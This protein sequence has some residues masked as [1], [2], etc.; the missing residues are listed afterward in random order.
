MNGGR[1][2]IRTDERRSGRIYSPHPLATWIPYLGS[3]CEWSHLVDK[4][5]VGKWFFSIFEFD[6]TFQSFPFQLFILLSMKFS[7][8]HERIVVGL[9]GSIACGKSAVLL[10]LGE[11]GW[12]CFSTDKIAHR[13]LLE[14]DEV[15]Q[16]IRDEFGDAVFSSEGTV[17]KARLG[18]V[19]F[20]QSSKR[21][22]LEELLHPLIRKEWLHAVE[23]S[24]AKRIAVE[25]PLLF[26]NALE[27]EF[28]QVVTVFTNETTQMKRLLQRGLSSTEAEQRIS[29]QLPSSE[30]ARMADFVLF[31]D[32]SL[33]YLRR[34]VKRL[35]LNLA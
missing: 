3:F 24:E 28:D 20:S 31:G 29:S 21:R 15:I 30:K 9:T 2:R 16:S 5:I 34:Q 8:K 4:L 35:D 27:T 1:G 26:E 13:L 14:K 7:G 17:D 23:E 6:G 19:V 33:D 10:L 32:G 25:V 12:D 18:S 11:L 22:W